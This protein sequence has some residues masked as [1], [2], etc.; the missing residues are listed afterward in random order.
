MKVY[1]E[2]RSEIEAR[3]R[4]S[5]LHATIL[6]PWYVLGPGHAWPYAL[7]PVY[8][9]ME[10]IPSTRAGAQRLGLVTLEQMLRALTMAAAAPCTGVRVLGVPEIRNGALP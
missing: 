5:G 2:V 9:L 4:E 6:K 10:R 7:I 1:Q 3:I 8:W